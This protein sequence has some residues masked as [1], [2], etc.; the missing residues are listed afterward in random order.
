M[1]RLFERWAVD[2]ALILTILGLSLFGTA[3]IYSAGQVHVPNPVT[4]GAWLRQ[5]RWFAIALVAFTLVSRVPVRWIE[6]VAVP[7][8]VLSL[9]LLSVTL[10]IGTGAGTAAG[11]KSWIDLGPV[12]FQP[13]ELAKIST[14]LVL[15]RLLS[16]RLDPPDSLRDMLVPSVLVG[17]PLG[18]VILQP[19]LGTAMA[20]VGMLLAMLFWAGTPVVLLLLV[21]SPVVGLV[22]SFDTAVWSWYIVGVVG[23]LYLYRY[24]LFLVE[25]VGIV[26]ANFAAGTIARPLW[27]SL[28]EYQQN[29][30]LVFLDPDVDPRGAGYQI[31]QSLV[32]IGSGGLRGKGFT[33]GPQKRFDF[34]P[35]QHTDFIFSVIGEE[36]GFLG[37]V[38][39]I[40]GFAYLLLRL[41][42]MA[43]DTGDAF[44]GLILLGIFGAWLVHIFVNIGMTVGVVPITGIP[45]PFIS[46][47]G[48][49][50]LMSWVAAAIAVRVAHE[51]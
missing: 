28:A 34:L 12:S 46:Y 29:R 42:R 33:L 39:T 6:W 1:I 5:A 49:F 9:V 48:T 23:F 20:F 44:A 27:N 22:L 17:L 16:Q 43:Q 25:S 10:I 41:V 50:L 30:I 2:P 45:L 7:S 26:I 35:E 32:A 40:V 14:V 24:R 15:A 4:H 13:A 18:L 19:D 47:G 37:T 3:M 8:Y 38:V 11:V 21:A 31:I 51:R 36:L